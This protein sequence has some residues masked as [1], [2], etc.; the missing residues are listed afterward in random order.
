LI[1]TA[2]ASFFAIASTSCTTDQMNQF[3]QNVAALTPSQSYTFVR[4]N[5]SYTFTTHKTTYSD[6]VK[7]LGPPT[8]SGTAPD[9]SNVIRNG[10]LYVV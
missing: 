3:K 2:F 10:R 5:K 6:V 1:T 8:K 7:Q 4:D 9:G